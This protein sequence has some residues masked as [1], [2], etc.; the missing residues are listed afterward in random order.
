MDR[1]LRVPLYLG[2]FSQS[3]GANSSI[4]YR[5]LLARLQYGCNTFS[6]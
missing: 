4:P 5:T 1:Y 2:D 3:G 6:D